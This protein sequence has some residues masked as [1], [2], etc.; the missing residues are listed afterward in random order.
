MLKTGNEK[1]QKEVADKLGISLDVDLL[2]YPHHG[3]ASLYD[4]FL[5]YAKPEYTVVPNNNK[6]AYPNSTNKAMLDKYNVKM[7]R[8]SD[9]STGNI[10]VT[11]DGNKIEITMN[12]KAE[13][14]KR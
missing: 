12:V 9:S 14:Y 3:N 2:K 13:Q 11:S 5:L 7:Y 1:T 6:P 10:L 4:N 8:Q